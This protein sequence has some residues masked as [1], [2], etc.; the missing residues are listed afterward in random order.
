[1]NRIEGGAARGRGLRVTAL[2]MC[3]FLWAAQPAVAQDSKSDA[4][5]GAFSQAESVVQAH[6]AAHPDLM[7]VPPAERAAAHAK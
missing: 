2:L 6:V 5:P 1:M 7:N 4:E 3:S